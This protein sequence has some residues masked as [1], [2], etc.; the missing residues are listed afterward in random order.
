MGLSAPRDYHIEIIDYQPVKKLIWINP[1][2]VS[3]PWAEYLE[4]IALKPKNRDHPIGLSAS[5]ANSLVIIA[6]QEVKKHKWRTQLDIVPLGPTL[7][8]LLPRIQ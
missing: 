4:I 2:G 7:L 5:W 8:R 6:L 3:D 1:M